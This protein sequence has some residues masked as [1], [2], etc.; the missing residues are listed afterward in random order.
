MAK[1]SDKQWFAAE[2]KS[3]MQSTPGQTHIDHA[4]DHLAAARNSL[5]AGD[6]DGASYHL[7]A[8]GTHATAGA[9][10]FGTHSKSWIQGAIKHPGSFTKQAKKAH[11][12]VQGF[13]NKV[14]A[15]PSKFSTTTKRRA[16]LAKTLASFHK[17]K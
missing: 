11:E 10:Y 12:S 8:A 1:L 7:G 17:G 16:N 3:K 13:A 14:K 6:H 15:N 4:S 5:D 2:Q 9:N